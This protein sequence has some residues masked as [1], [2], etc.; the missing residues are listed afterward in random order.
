M[1]RSPLALL[2]RL[3]SSTAV[4]ESKPSSRNARS[5]GTASAPPWPSTCATIPRTSRATCVRASCGSRPAS[6]SA[7]VPVP[8]RR[9]FAAG[10]TRPRSITGTRPAAVRARMAGRSTT[11]GTSAAPPWVRAAS[12]SPSP[13]GA[14]IGTRPARVTRARSVSLIDAAM[15]SVSH[16][17]HARLTAGSPRCARSTARASRKALPAAYAAWP[18]EPSTPATEEKSTNRSRSSS[19]V[20]S[21]SHQPAVTF[22][23]STSASW[24]AV[25]PLTMPSSRTPAVWTTPARRSSAVMDRTSS[26]TRSRS[27]TSVA[28]TRAV[29][30]SAASRRTSSSAPGAAGPCRDASTSDRTP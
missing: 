14:V 20:A 9:R 19:A 11:A 8:E 22:G 5:A 24:S 15:P 26:P 2:I 10:P 3:R 1:S 23:A 18:G 27:V 30:P 28:T 12:H 13:T 25:I 4:S 16:M 29:A 6:R 7:H 17:P 21:C